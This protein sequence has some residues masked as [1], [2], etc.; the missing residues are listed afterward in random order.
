MEERQREREEVRSGQGG[1][2]TTA[3]MD[4]EV[5]SIVMVTCH[6]GAIMG[7]LGSRSRA[8]VTTLFSAF[9]QA[10]D[11]K[12]SV[13]QRRDIENVTSVSPCGNKPCKIY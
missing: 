5:P 3:Q 11:D 12:N 7:L 2:I 10:F 4:G 13:F 1:S 9:H 8:I 6:T